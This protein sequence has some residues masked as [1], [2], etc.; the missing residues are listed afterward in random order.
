MDIISTRVIRPKDRE[1]QVLANVEVTFDTGISLL[2][3]HLL[4]ARKEG[5]PN[6]LKMPSVTT[7]TGGVHGVYNPI[8]REMREKMTEAAEAALAQAVE[9][10]VNDFTATFVEMKPEAYRAPKFSD[11]QLHWFDNDKPVRAFVSLLMDDCIALNRLVVVRDVNTK[12]LTV[13]IPMHPLPR[14]RRQIGYYRI[15]GAAYDQLYN[16]VMPAII[17]QAIAEGILNLVWL[18]DN[19][20]YALDIVGNALYRLSA[21]S[22]EEIKEMAAEYTRINDEAKRS[23]MSRIKKG[24]LRPRLCWK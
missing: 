6:Y 16:Q 5:A 3:M 12:M 19:K 2:N 14:R 7:Q 13:R 4:K 20:I 24:T 17:E 11:F 18:P 10:G 9:A 15:Q 1:S 22:I 21:F 23:I 8:T